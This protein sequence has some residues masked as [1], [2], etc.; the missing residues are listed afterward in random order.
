MAPRP[1]IA[2]AAARI[3]SALVIAVAPLCLMRVT[4]VLEGLGPSNNRR[5]AGQMDDPPARAGMPSP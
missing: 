3:K 4:R 1:I 5:K 2:A